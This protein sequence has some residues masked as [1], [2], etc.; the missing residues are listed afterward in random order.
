MHQ[1]VVGSIPGQGTCLG[2]RFNP[3]CGMYGRQPVDGSL[4]NRC[5][6]LTFSLSKIN[7]SMSSDVDLKKMNN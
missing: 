7:G 5:I 2:Y 4:S 6:S 1:R 3:S